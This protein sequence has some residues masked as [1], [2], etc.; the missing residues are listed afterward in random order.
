MGDAEQ[1]QSLLF[2]ALGRVADHSILATYCPLQKEEPK[3]QTE[4]VFKRLLEAS[5]TKLV[6]N[7]RQRLQWSKGCVCCLMDRTGENF[8]CL[9]T[10]SMEYP[11]SY[12]FKLLQEFLNIAQQH[13]L[14]HALPYSL[15]PILQPVMQ[16]LIVI[17]EDPITFGNVNGQGAKGGVAQSSMHDI[18]NSPREHTLEQE[19]GSMAEGLRQIDDFSAQLAYESINLPPYKKARVVGALVLIVICSITLVMFFWPRGSGLVKGSAEDNDAGG[20]W[21]AGN[22]SDLHHL[23]LPAPPRQPIPQP[24]PQP[25]FG[26]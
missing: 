21:G 4:D 10:S 16:C 24:I 7:Q 22:H 20:T 19:P 9:V 12:A 26:M 17:Y 25:P 14:K 8:Y 6:A 1:T 3:R 11:E 2:L 18:M 15:S 5:K 13:E 23:F